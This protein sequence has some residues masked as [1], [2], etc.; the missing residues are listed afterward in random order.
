MPRGLGRQLVDVEGLADQAY[1][2]YLRAA[3]T[4]TNSTELREFSL[5]KAHVNREVRWFAPHKPIR[6]IEISVAVPPLESYHSPK[7]AKAIEIVCG[8]FLL[9]TYRE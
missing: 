5:M 3:G 4:L 8:P 2:A 6:T 7:H 1:S 9:I